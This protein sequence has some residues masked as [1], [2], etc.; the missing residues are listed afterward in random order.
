MAV[1]LLFNLLLTT[2][3]GFWRVLLPQKK[4]QWDFTENPGFH[5]TRFFLNIIESKGPTR[6]RDEFFCV[7]LCSLPRVTPEPASRQSACPPATGQSGV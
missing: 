2:S 7:L 1:L 6:R 3:F 5:R 4:S